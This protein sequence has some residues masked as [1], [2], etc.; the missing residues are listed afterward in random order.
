MYVYPDGQM[1]LLSVND[2]RVSAQSRWE[3]DSGMLTIIEQD[4][5]KTVFVIVEVPGKLKK[6]D[7]HGSAYAWG[8]RLLFDTARY[9]YF[10]TPDINAEC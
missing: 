10:S 2:C 1:V 3:F 8:Q 9:W 6:Y 4:G 5:G 7:G